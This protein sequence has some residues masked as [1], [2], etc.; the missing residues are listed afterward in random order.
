MKKNNTILRSEF[1]H[2]F[3]LFTLRAYI[4]NQ[5]TFVVTDFHRTAAVQNKRFKKGGTLCDGYEKISYHQKRRAKDLVIINAR[6]KLIWDYT[7]EYDTLAKIWK[8]LKGRWGGDW[9]KQGKT[10]FNDIYHFE[11]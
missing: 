10:T 9:F 1:G 8:E 3:A 6:G 4:I 2:K 11:C 7:P 5:I